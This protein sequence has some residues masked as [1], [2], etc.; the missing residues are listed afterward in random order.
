LL[1]VCVTSRTAKPRYSDPDPGSS[2]NAS[3]TCRR[4]ALL[5]ILERSWRP[6]VLG[7][8]PV[9]DAQY[10]VHGTREEMGAA[11]YPQLHACGLM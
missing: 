9:E 6:V 1:D 10:G 3:V 11:V 4:S 2:G 7:I 8:R 5:R